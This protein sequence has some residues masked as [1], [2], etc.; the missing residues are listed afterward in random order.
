MKEYIIRFEKGRRIATIPCDNAQDK[1]NKE[2]QANLWAKNK[3]DRKIMVS[4]DNR[5]HIKLVGG[6]IEKLT[7]AEIDALKPPK[8]RDVF[9]ELDDLAARVKALE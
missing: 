7:Q 8:P 3:P 5:N 4:T 9:K 6:K 1:K 2:A